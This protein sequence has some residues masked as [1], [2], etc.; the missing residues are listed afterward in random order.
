MQNYFEYD[1]SQSWAVI[2]VIEVIHDCQC[3]SLVSEWLSLF[4]CLI[5]K[6]GFVA[7]RVCWMYERIVLSCLNM[8]HTSEFNMPA[9]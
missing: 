5:M 2:M 4:A 6:K 3:V 9:K 1:Y 8:V 7:E